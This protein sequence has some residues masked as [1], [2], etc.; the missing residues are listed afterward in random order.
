MRILVAFVYCLM[1][2]AGCTD[3][4]GRTMVVNSSV[5]GDSI[6]DSRTDLDLGTAAFHCLHSASGQCHYALFVNGSSFRTFSLA[7][8]DDLKLVGLP[9]DFVQCVTQQPDAVTADCKPAARK[10]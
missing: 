9:D 3:G 10:S 1:S 4:R 6:L 5:N 7:A 2:L 8:G